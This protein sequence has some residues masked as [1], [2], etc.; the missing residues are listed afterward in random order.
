MIEDLNLTS[1]L[2]YGAQPLRCRPTQAG[3]LLQA[4]R[5]VLR[6]PAGGPLHGGVGNCTRR[7]QGDSDADAA[8][9][10]RAVENLLHNAACHNPGPVQVQLRGA[11]RKNTE[12][13]D[14]RRRRGLPGS[15]AARLA[16]R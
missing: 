2:Q 6:K 1:K 16:D 14:S 5:R 11:H 7:R 15:G 13:H 12:D 3:L 4:G 9:L 10:A 8:L